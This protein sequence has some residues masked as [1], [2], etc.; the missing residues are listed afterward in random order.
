MSKASVGKYLFLV[1][2]GCLFLF[3]TIASSNPHAIISAQ[4]TCDPKYNPCTETPTNT[5]IPKVSPTNTYLPKTSDTPAKPTSTSTPKPTVIYPT[6]TPTFT[7]SPTTTPTFTLPP[8]NTGTASPKPTVL[9]V[10]STSIPSNTPIPQRPVIPNFGLLPGPFIATLI[11]I[12]VGDIWV[13]GMEMTQAIQVYGT[14]GALDNGIPLVSGKKTVVRV[15]VQSDNFTPPWNNVTA[16]LTVTGGREPGR[17]LLPLTGN[18]SASIQVS[19]GGSRRI[20]WSDSFNFLLDQD[21]TSTGT[22]HFSV[23]IFSLDPRPELNTA[24][25]HFEMDGRFSPVP[26]IVFMGVVYENDGTDP[27]VPF[28]AAAPWLDFFKHSVVAENMSPV[29]RLSVIYFPGLGQS[30]LIVPNLEAA[31]SW[32]DRILARPEYRSSRIYLLQPEGGCNCGQASDRRMNGQNNLRSQGGT[33]AQ[34][35]AHSYGLWW[36]AVSPEH[37]ADLQNPLYPYTHGSV[38]SQV[39]EKTYSGGSPLI[40]PMRPDYGGGLHAH[41]FMSYGTSPIWVSPFTYCAYL[42]VLT[43]GTLTCPAGAERASLPSNSNETG[44]TH[45]ADITR[46]TFLYVAGTIF[47]DGTASFEPFDQIKSTEDISQIPAGNEFHLIFLGAGEDT[48]QDIPFQPVETHHDEEHPTIQFN[49]TVP[50]PSMTNR[51]LLVKDGKVLAEKTVS[52]HSPSVEFNFQGTGQTESGL[53]TFTWKATDADGDPLHYS[54]EYSRDGGHTWLII[55]AGMDKP[56]AKID[57]DSLPGTEQ[58]MLRI[59]AS[60]GVLSS[61]AVSTGTFTVASK[62]PI[63]NSISDD[64]TT[65]QGQPIFVEVRAFDWEDGDIS[66]PSAI[67]WS[68]DKDGALTSGAWIAPGNLSV[69]EHTLTATVHDSDGNTTSRSMHVTVMAAAKNT[70]SG[71]VGL[72]DYLVKIAAGILVVVVFLVIFLLIVIRRIKRKGDNLVTGG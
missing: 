43:N 27:A 41:D 2:V 49:L 25:N 7:L 63:I 28:L 56:E 4:V 71:P 44:T 50:Y 51:I 5:Y 45:L 67:T 30:P 48:L 10:T 8:T 29:A 6:L 69:G 34:E 52:S 14:G 17:I 36:H 64:L 9:G 62:A 59:T 33:M 57:F 35:V 24:N 19:P 39:G 72:M 1:S 54:I 13:T 16:R 20:W 31:R 3:M 68:S 26:N 23:E 58:G 32:A 55:N 65:Y 66:D 11:P 38:G 60:D 47:P 53:Q 42:S 22:R 21:E 40:F 15:Y 46:A 37:P 61:E 70:V 18:S 12:P